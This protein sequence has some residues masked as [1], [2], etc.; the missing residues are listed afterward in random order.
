MGNEY[1]LNNYIGFETKQ[2]RKNKLI[3]N[4]IKLG[5]ESKK[6][7][8]FVNHNVKI[9]SAPIYHANDE[10]L[11]DILSNWKNDEDLRKFPLTLFLSN[12]INSN[13]IEKTNGLDIKTKNSKFSVF[14]IEMEKN[15]SLIEKLKKFQTGNYDK[16]L[17]LRGFYPERKATFNYELGEIFEKISGC[18]K[19][20]RIRQE[21]DIK[22][23]QIN[24]NNSIICNEETESYEI[25]LDSLEGINFHDEI[26]EEKDIKNLAWWYGDIEKPLWKKEDERLQ[27]KA[28]KRLLKKLKKEE[29]LEKKGKIKKAIGKLEKRLTKNI[30]GIEVEL[31]NEKYDAK[32]SWFASLWAMPDGDIIKELDTLRETKWDC[33]NGYNIIKHKS[34][35]DLI[36]SIIKRGKSR[37]GAVFIGHN[38]VYD[39]IQS[40]EAA[41]TSGAEKFDIAVEDISPKR[42]FVRKYYQRM[43]EDFIYLDTLWLSRI[44][45]P[46][47]KTKMPEG[48]HK[49]EDVSNFVG[50]NFEKSLN[51]EEL[52][53]MEIK[54]I[55]AKKKWMR[56]RAARKLAKYASSDVE[57]LKFIMDTQNFLKFLLKIKKIMP[58][59]TL[60]E[61]AFSPRCVD[62]YLDKEYFDRFHTQR[63]FGYMKKEREDKIQ[64]FKKRFPKI[65]KDCL[66]FFDIEVSPSYGNYDNIHQL[67]FSLEEHLLPAVFVRNIKW[68]QLY[69]DTKKDKKENFAALQYIKALSRDMLVDYYFCKRERKLYNEGIKK[70]DFFEK[71]FLTF[72]NS[73]NKMNR[74]GYSYCFNL[75]KNLYRSIYMDIEGKER[76]IIRKASETSSSQMTFGFID[77]ITEGNEDLYKIRNNYDK[78]KENLDEKGKKNLFRF[79]K[80]FDT[81]D[82]YSARLEIDA[83][84]IIGNKGEK[85]EI[86]RDF[87]YLFNQKKRAEREEKSFVGKY[88]LYPYGG[89]FSLQTMVYNGYKKLADELK[90]KKAEIV[91]VRG[92]YI[93]VRAESPD[94]NESIVKVIRKIEK[95]FRVEKPLNKLE[96]ETESLELS[97]PRK[98]LAVA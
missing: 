29:D 39:I 73:S 60:T 47:L 15:P 16:M 30:G 55:S 62:K 89:K 91:Q 2:K 69:E 57:P 7:K 92:D 94:F 98:K 43:R 64:I 37:N 27:I 70:N 95:D 80:I 11:N 72:E 10:D 3:L 31:F 32:V 56:W 78:L 25:H 58:Y 50:Y 93:F 24:K 85:K 6:A 21:T 4:F 28:R 36:N 86:A 84:N 65:K 17:K 77:E 14:E 8:L 71:F 90:N 49:L 88:G 38:S 75:L 51:Y 53:E 18:E 40:R 82:E 13:A 41:K 19:D 63:D 83:A 26:I 81:F 97:F 67:Y 76:K 48:S 87:V 54:A 66:E 12:R 34:E 61:I 52:R 20:E 46:Y 45:F 59:A 74:N 22:L 68:K 96:E 35:K 23:K 79:M 44:F 33:V 9:N 5:N 1:W 42:D